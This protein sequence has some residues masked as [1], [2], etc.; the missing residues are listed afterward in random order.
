MRGRPAR[1]NAAAVVGANLAALAALA[2]VSAGISAVIGMAGGVTLLSG[3]LMVIPPATAVPIHGVV[4]LASNSTR[5]LV[6]FKHVRWRIVGWFGVFAAPGA[7]LGATVVRVTPGAWLTLAI[8]IFILV[9]THLP[10]PNRPRGGDIKRAWIFGPVGFAA[11]FLGMLVGAT[12]PLIAPF[13]LRENV[14]KEELIA[15]KAFCQAFVHLWKL[16][17]FMA[18]GFDYGEHLGALALLVTMVIVGTL[19]GKRLLNRVSERAFMVLIKA[20]LT[21]IALKLVAVDALPALLS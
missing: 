11:G 8:G 13:F 6:F 15:T 21:L 14:L 12:G 7:A 17:A 20:A 2:M 9:A 18:I 5:L 16:P 1:D 19:L 4:Q 10:T 3:M